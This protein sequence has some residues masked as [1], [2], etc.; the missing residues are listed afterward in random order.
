MRIHRTWLALVLIA[1][2]VMPMAA[3]DI[4]ASGPPR[5]IHRSASR[6]YT[7]DF[8]VKDSTLTGKIK[9]DMGESDVLEGKVEG[10]K[11]SFARAAVL[12]REWKFASPIPGL[13]SPPRDQV[14]SQCRRFRYRRARREASEV[15]RGRR[16]QSY[17]GRGTC[18]TTIMLGYRTARRLCLSG[19]LLCLIAATAV[20]AAQE[21]PKI[22]PSQHGSLLQRIA[23]TT[24]ALKYNRPVARGRNLF[25]ALVPYGKIWCPCADDATTIEL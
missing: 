7:Y 5:S 21:A 18:D 25:G 9:S 4:P 15:G 22:K 3:A 12:S 17:I 14:H 10:D 19:S 24:I 1:I 2:M 13:S 16:R 23:E 6:N 11:V 20:L 8:V